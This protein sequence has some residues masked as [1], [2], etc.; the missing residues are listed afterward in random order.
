MYL[1]IKDNL[2]LVSERFQ[3]KDTTHK[4]EVVNHIL[5]L[6]ASGSMSWTMPKLVDDVVRQLDNFTEDS[7]LSIGWFSSKNQ[8]G[9]LVKGMSASNRASIGKILRNQN[10]AFNMTCFSDILNDTKLLIQDLRNISEN[11]SLMFFSDGAVNQDQSTVRSILQELA[12]KLTTAI[13][14]G[15]GDWYDRCQMSEMAQTTGGLLLHANNITDFSNH[16]S[17]FRSSS[18]K[19][20]PKIRLDNV[21]KEKL[22]L[23]ALTDAKDIISVD[24]ESS[25][26]YLPLNVDKLVYLTNTIPT[27]D[28]DGV[29]EDLTD[30]IYAVTRSLLQSGN[31]SLALDVV[32][33]LGDVNVI[34]SINNSF[35]VSEYGT[36]ENLLFN[37]IS[38]KS[39]RFLKGQKS[40]YVAK[41]DAF[42]LIDLIDLLTTDA[43]VKFH[44]YHPNFDYK[45]VGRR[46]KQKDGYPEFYPD[47]SDGV[48]LNSLT[49]SSDKL[50]LSV[51][52]KI[53]GHIILD[54]KS[55]EF[56]FD[57]TFN[58]FVWR[59]YTLISDGK[60]N[61]TSLPISG[62]SN[63][64]LNVLMENDLVLNPFNTDGIFV[65]DLTKIPVINRLVAKSYLDLD[66]VCDKLYEEKQL[67]ALNKV[68]N[69]KY[70]LLPE[71]LKD[72]VDDL[73]Y[74]VS[75]NDSQVE[76][77][78]KFG[79]KKD[80]SFSPETELEDP[81][82]ILTVK[83]VKFGIS[84][85]SS[86]PKVEDV[87]NKAKTGKKLTPVQE[88]LHHAY[89]KLPKDLTKS[90]EALFIKEEMISNRYK[91]KELRSYI[92]KAK[93]AV[94]LG[95][96]KFNQLKKFEEKNVYE[97]N[98]ISYTLSFSD[99]ELK[100]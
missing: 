22:L 63:Q 86:L 77:L 88:L 35:T 90:Q 7:L 59:N 51:L 53:P 23:L 49:W 34:D 12:P 19:S 18:E 24:L 31:Y 2:Y 92:S 95:K 68:Y 73:V 27:K 1:K 8:Y 79:I 94:I 87:L 100:I 80:G 14:V 56:G 61:I 71:D 74:N 45:R 89:E 60:A 20:K 46:A 26:L 13:Y 6:D 57:N 97:R 98:G 44:P 69:Y 33:K 4:K 5:L 58:T 93:L 40:N 85:M 55:S 10:W 36:V 43:N 82:D 15:Y 25:E 96:T 11:F 62:V 66:I 65:L 99:I 42:C 76:Y 28:K 30:E 41:E 48:D 75:F 78:D 64:T 81:T 37:A 3:K 83:S 54:R 84:G 16:F 39:F 32:G 9:W 52:A 50:N 29:A 70:S 17:Y 38:D 67:E 47:K 21:F 91:L 72:K